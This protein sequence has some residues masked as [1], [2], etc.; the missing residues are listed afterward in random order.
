M[1]A[2]NFC[3]DPFNKLVRAILFSHAYLRT[4]AS[5]MEPGQPRLGGYH[6]R[7]VS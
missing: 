1:G 2:V 4:G 6:T 7:R 3:S 5:M